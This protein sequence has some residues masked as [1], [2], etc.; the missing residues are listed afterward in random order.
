ML[1][2][3]F[4]LGSDPYIFAVGLNDFWTW[5]KKQAEIV[6]FIV[7][8]VLLIAAII[9][10]AWVSAIGILIGLSLIGIFILEPKALLNLSEWLGGLLGIN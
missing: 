2:A 5:F 8:L 6:L 9:K 10:R 3:L 7:L 4:S 1:D